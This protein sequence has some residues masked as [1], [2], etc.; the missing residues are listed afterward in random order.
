L[1]FYGLEFYGYSFDLSSIEGHLHFIDAGQGHVEVALLGSTVDT[2]NLAF[3][4]AGR[5]A[6][7]IFKGKPRKAV[8]LAHVDR[9]A[10]LLWG[11]HSALALGSALFKVASALFA[12]LLG[13][14]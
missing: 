4:E 10:L 9:E 7:E 3:A 12:V 14:H 11:I 6:Q 1:I 8:G 2:L 13:T 5:F